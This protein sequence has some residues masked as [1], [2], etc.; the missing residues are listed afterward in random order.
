MSNWAIPLLVDG[1]LPFV[2][3]VLASWLWD[4]YKASDFAATHS[5]ASTQKRID[6]LEQRLRVFGYVLEDHNRFLAQFILY[7]VFT[8]ISF[9]S[10]VLLILLS[11]INSVEATIMLLPN[12]GLRTGF[13]EILMSMSFWFLSAGVFACGVSFSLNL[14]RL[15]SQ[16]VPESYKCQLSERIAR[17]RRRL[18]HMDGN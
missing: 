16:C 15:V 6:K 1:I 8:I 4:K 11:V 5:V 18:P 10:I 9:L 7:S 12:S 2:A 3:A 14:R 13:H 17:L